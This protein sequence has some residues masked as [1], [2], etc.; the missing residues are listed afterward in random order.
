MVNPV[1]HFENSHLAN[2]TVNKIEQNSDDSFDLTKKTKKRRPQKT[3]HFN[4]V[5]YMNYC[6]EKR[7]F[8]RGKCVEQYFTYE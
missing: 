8:F 1:H 3:S 5:A 6:H 2:A 7:P 4:F